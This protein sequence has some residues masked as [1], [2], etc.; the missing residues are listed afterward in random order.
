MDDQSF[1]FAFLS[2]GIPNLLESPPGFAYFLTRLHD[3]LSQL[4]GI[5]IL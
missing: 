1:E 4:G 2:G 3:N 5:A